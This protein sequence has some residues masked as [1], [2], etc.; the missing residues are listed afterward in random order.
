MDRRKVYIYK[1]ASDSDFRA[2]A[3]DCHMNQRDGEDWKELWFLTPPDR[4]HMIQGEVLRETEDGFIFRS[5][6]YDPGEWIFKVL[7][8][9]DFKREYFK[10]VVGGK[11]LAQTIKTTK[12]LHEWYRKEF[13]F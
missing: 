9:Q 4:G 11:V 10:N 13:H 7:T 2:L 1:T 3:C 12:N 8:I 6:G 5:D